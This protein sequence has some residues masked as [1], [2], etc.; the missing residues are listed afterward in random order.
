MKRKEL[1]ES[2]KVR[3][4]YICQNGFFCPTAFEVLPGKK[5][6]VHHKTPRRAGGTD[7][8]ENLITF[9]KSC[10]RNIELRS[11]TLMVEGYRECDILW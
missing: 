8:P 6:D 11:Q 4:E 1:A 7:D 5:L 3:D 9:C 2:I 10:H